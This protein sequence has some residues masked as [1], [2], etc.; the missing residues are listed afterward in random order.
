L[1]YKIRTATEPDVARCAELLEI[2][3]SQEHEF[4]SN[5]EA[6]SRALSMIIRNPDLGRIFVGD[7]EGVIQGMVMLLFT[8]STFLGKKAALLED[9]VVAPA[10]RSKG[11]GTQLIDHAVNFARRE[12]FGRITLLTDSDNKTAQQFYRSQGFLK[13]GM[14]VFRKLLDKETTMKNSNDNVRMCQECGY[15]YDPAEGD[16][17]NAIKPGTP[18][19]QISDEWACPV[20]FA[21]KAMFVILT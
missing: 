10:W 6:Q 4:A 15:V 11:L 16:P 5:T 7:I 19:D 2:L 21:G 13:S 9:M 12:G 14:I 1:I 3:F 20:C 18:F 8:V 17:D